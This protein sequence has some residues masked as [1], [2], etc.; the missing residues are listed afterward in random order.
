[1]LDV[2]F[3][4]IALFSGLLLQIS[5]QMPQAEQRLAKLHP[6]PGSYARMDRMSWILIIV[7]SLW[8]LQNL[9]V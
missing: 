2:W 9:L 3:P 7:G 4:L 8:A 1:M 5:L 6:I